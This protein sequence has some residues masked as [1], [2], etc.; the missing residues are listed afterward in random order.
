MGMRIVEFASLGCNEDQINSVWYKVHVIQGLGII[1]APVLE[2]W[3]L[4]LK[5]LCCMFKVEQLANGCT[6]F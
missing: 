3:N 1:S 5:R 6:D 4:I 2:M